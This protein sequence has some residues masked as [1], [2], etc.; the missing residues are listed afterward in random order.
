MTEDKSK[1][2]REDI[3]AAGYQAVKQLIKIAK[4][5]VINPELY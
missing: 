4:E 3:I 2:I 5:E 1:K